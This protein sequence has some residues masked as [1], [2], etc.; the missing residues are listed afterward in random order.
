MATSGWPPRHSYKFI[1]IVVPAQAGS[2]FQGTILDP[3]L[4]RDDDIEL[5][6]GQLSTRRARRFHHIQQ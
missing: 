3:G 1:D 4:R 6:S 2:Q 5:S